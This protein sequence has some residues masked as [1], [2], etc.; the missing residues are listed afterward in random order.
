MPCKERYHCMFKSY[1]AT[2]MKR[3]EVLNKE[4]LAYMQVQRTRQREKCNPK[5][6]SYE[7]SKQACAEDQDMLEGE[8]GTQVRD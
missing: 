3:T 4:E 1:G 7:V 5:N 8:Q 6:N 2:H